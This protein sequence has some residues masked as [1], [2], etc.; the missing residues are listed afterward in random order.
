MA[1][2]EIDYKKYKNEY[3]KLNQDEFIKL[4]NAYLADNSIIFFEKKKYFS[5]FLREFKFELCSVVPIG[6]FCFFLTSFTFFQ[7]GF[8]GVVILVLDIGFAISFIGYFISMFNFIESIVFYNRY[9][10]KLNKILKSADNWE[11]FK[12][13]WID[14]TN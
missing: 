5:E 12:K 7:S 3:F 1:R 4:R 14:T 6:F 11:D 9:H 2:I 10:Q 8:F 13:M